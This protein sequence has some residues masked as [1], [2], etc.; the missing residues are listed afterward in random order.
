MALTLPADVSNISQDA[1]F[2][3]DAIMNKQYGLFAS[4]AIVVVISLLRKYVPETTQVGKF[5][6]WR[7]GAMITNFVLAVGGAFGTMFAAGQV[8]DG[9]MLLQALGIGFAAAGGWAIFKNIQD[10]ISES[11][12][13]KAGLVAVKNPDETVNK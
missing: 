12:A 4:F 1:Q 5:F 8:F 3:Y 13:Q 11:K 7:I 2:L 9:K 10:E 6:Q